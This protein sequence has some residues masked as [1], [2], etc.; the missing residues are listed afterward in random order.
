MSEVLYKIVKGFILILVSSIVGMGLIMISYTIPVDKIKQNV[1]RGSEVMLNQGPAYI[2][3]G[4][5][6]E[7]VLDNNT[8]ALILAKAAYKSDSII[9]SA[10]Y[11]PSLYFDEDDGP[12]YSLYSYF[13]NDPDWTVGYYPRYWHGYVV[14]LKP[15]FYFLDFADFRILNQ[16][17]QLFLLMAV[18]YLLISRKK[19]EYLLAFIPMMV[20]WNPATIGISLQYAPCFYISMIGTI[21]AFFLK[22][23]NLW[24]LFL[25]LGILTAYFD[26]LTYPLVTLAV[27]L[28][29]FLIINEDSSKC[30]K[31]GALTLLEESIFWGG[32]ICRYVDDEMG[33][34]KHS[35]KAEFIC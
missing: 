34:W 28:V 27:P 13:H 8:D 35:D 23:D 32:W 3:A 25:F 29:T 12:F 19:G 14:L 10:V 5:Y 9:E 22:K 1:E 30:L 24:K 4:E 15:F 2:Y 20:F 31:T 11:V 21:F 33:C 16:G 6:T 26:F 18:V 17:V 7:A